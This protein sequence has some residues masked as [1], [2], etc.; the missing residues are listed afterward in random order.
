M[1]L[2]TRERLRNNRA[3][4]IGTA[5]ALLSAALAYVVFVPAPK[6]THIPQSPLAPS[7]PSVVS[8]PANAQELA[9]RLA[10]SAGNTSLPAQLYPAMTDREQLNQANQRGCIEIGAIKKRAANCQFGDP[11]GTKSMWLIGDSHAGQWF[12]AID[13]YARANGYRLTVHAKASCVPQ[14]PNASEAYYPECDGMNHF[15]NRQITAEHPDVVIVGAFQ[16]V[17]RKVLP[18]M[19]AKLP[20]LAA[21]TDEL[22]LIGDT[23]RQSGDTPACILSNQTDYSGCVSLRNK[24][25]YSWVGRSLAKLAD[26]NPKIHYID[27]RDWFC[28]AD[29]CPPIVDSVLIYRDQN[30]LS[31]YAAVWL[32]NVMAGTLDAV[33]PASD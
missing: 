29:V 12:Y 11:N 5:A 27:T 18:F 3:I 13:A 10:A 21:K 7:L 19:L 6:A 28:T 31:G 26:E 17:A 4:F 16:S 22:V 30:H 25:Y 23:P 32:T 8:A 2:P 1:A 14:L 33:L 20:A 15:W 9:A 24:A